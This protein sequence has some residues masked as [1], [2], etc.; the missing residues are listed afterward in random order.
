MS[1]D[2]KTGRGEVDES[3]KLSADAAG[4][5][6]NSGLVKKIFTGLILAGIAW[7]AYAAYTKSESQEKPKSQ[8]EKDLDKI[9]KSQEKSTEAQSAQSG[10]LQAKMPHEQAQGDPDSLGVL[11]KVRAEKEAEAKAQLDAEETAQMNVE[12]L[13]YARKLQLLSHDGELA[14]RWEARMRQAAETGRGL[15]TRALTDQEEKLVQAKNPGV[16]TNLQKARALNGGKAPGS[17]PGGKPGGSVQL[18]AGAQP[19]PGAQ[20]VG[21]AGRP[22]VAPGGRVPVMPAALPNSIDPKTGLPIQAG[23]GAGAGPQGGAGEQALVSGLRP[24]GAPDIEGGAY[25]I[26]F[27]YVPIG[28]KNAVTATMWVKPGYLVGRSRPYNPAELAEAD[29]AYRTSLKAPSEV[30]E[31][32]SSSVVMGVR[33]PPSKLRV[34]PNSDFTFQQRYVVVHPNPDPRATLTPPNPKPPAPQN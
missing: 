32:E 14:S 8:A 12:Q 34:S 9:R 25:P 17:K 13:H 26:Q 18:A 10:K 21:P 29:R 20:P 4:G 16:W 5:V 28:E 30:I 23:A 27:S 19:V 22:A 24:D 11:A 3:G 6:A 33:V 7:F 2:N 31:K 15:E 1:E